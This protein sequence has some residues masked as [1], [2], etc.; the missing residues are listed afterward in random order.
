MYPRSPLYFAIR[1]IVAANRTAESAESQWAVKPWWPR[2]LADRKVILGSDCGVAKNKHRREREKTLRCLDAK[3]GFTLAVVR[4]TG[5][6]NPLR[7]CWQWTLVLSTINGCQLTMA[8]APQRVEAC[9][10]RP[11]C[12]RL[13]CGVTLISIGVRCCLSPTTPCTGRSGGRTRRGLIVSV[14]QC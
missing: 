6:S 13:L 7:A 14:R 1:P 10:R 2:C 3:P 5:E 12:H 11:F 4:I 8:T 9:H